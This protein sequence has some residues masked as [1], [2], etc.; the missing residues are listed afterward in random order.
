[1]DYPLLKS[2]GLVFNPK[3]PIPNPKWF[4]NLRAESDPKT[5]YVSVNQEW[6]MRVLKRIA[7][8]LDQLS[9][10]L[11]PASESDVGED[12]I[13]AGELHRH[14]LGEPEP[15]LSSLSHREQRAI[16]REKMGLSPM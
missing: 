5:A 16:L 10:N 3:S 14:R 13:T 8:N 2:Q 1:M 9:G 11:N 6:V 4:V 15:K 7:A 12:P